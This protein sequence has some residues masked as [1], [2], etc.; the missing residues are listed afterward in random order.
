MPNQQNNQPKA[1]PSNTQD[2][3]GSMKKEGQTGQDR[4]I[5]QQSPNRMNQNPSTDRK[6][7]K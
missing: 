4:K 5:D 6:S 7:Q 1:A 2:N 3:K